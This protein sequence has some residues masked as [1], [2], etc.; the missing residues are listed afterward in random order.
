MAER[1]TTSDGDGA[2]PGIPVPWLPPG[3]ELELAD[4]GTTFVRELAGPPGAPTALLL[5]GWT[6]TADLNFFT[7]YGA[8]AEHVNV[9]A[10]DH[11]GHGRGIRSRR[12]FRIEDCA[13]DA[14]AVADA[15]GIDRFVAV[16]YSM[17]GTIAQELWRRHRER[18][19]GLV[20][21]ATA[22]HFSDRREERLTF[23]GLGGLATLARITPHAARQWVTEQMYLQRKTEQ[24]E[25]WAVEAASSH[26]WRHVLEA[27]SAIGGFSSRQWLHEIDVP[28]S[29]VVTLRDHVIPVF[30][31]LELVEHIPDMDAFRVDADHDAVVAAAHRFVPTLVDAV[32]SVVHRTHLAVT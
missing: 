18:T 27:G 10:L 19:A 21:C 30:R 14:A 1:I 9:V 15:L 23:L 5:H 26:D 22:A 17:G 11:R 25:P 7:C 13:D 4:R 20:L 12:P 8:L 16:G 24:W 32:R 28:T 2:D 29:V 6:A 3:R 31:Q